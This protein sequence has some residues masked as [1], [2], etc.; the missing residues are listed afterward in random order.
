[1][2]NRRGEG[3]DGGIIVTPERRCN[4]RPTPPPFPLFPGLVATGLIVSL[5]RALHTP[6]SQR[7]SHTQPQGP[8]SRRGC[9]ESHSSLTPFPPLLAHRP[10]HLM[11]LVPT[12]SP[13]FPLPHSVRPSL[14]PAA[15][16]AALSCR[17]SPLA[18]PY[19]ANPDPWLVSRVFL[20]LH[21]GP[22]PPDPGDGGGCAP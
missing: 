15:F 12:C 14:S 6:S 17:G 20:P 22:P 11:V 5:P 21:L 19:G 4:P 1:M 16:D 18:Y 13:S 7:C 8:E 10:S 2:K 9:T 3:V